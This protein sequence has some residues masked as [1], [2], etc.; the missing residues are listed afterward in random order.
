MGH[1]NYPVWSL[2]GFP[3]TYAREFEDTKVLMRS[4][5]SKKTETDVEKA[6]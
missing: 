4:H 5:Q 2:C 6:K 1:L 3:S